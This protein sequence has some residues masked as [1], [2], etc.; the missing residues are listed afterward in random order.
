M[1]EESKHPSPTLVIHPRS[2]ST[3]PDSENFRRGPITDEDSCMF[4][5]DEFIRLRKNE[6]AEQFILD[7]K[8]NVEM[9]PPSWETVS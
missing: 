4:Q 1:N 2:R 9:Q 8:L 6:A 7:D 5:I 3:P